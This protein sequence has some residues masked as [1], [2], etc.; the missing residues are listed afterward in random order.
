VRL[1]ASR[2]HRNRRAHRARVG[3]VPTDNIKRRPVI[4]TGAH[5]RKPDGDVDRLVERQQFH[6]DQPLVVIHR[7]DGVELPIARREKNRV[8]RIRAGDVDS[9][10]A[11]HHDRRRDD[12]LF[13]VAE[14]AVLAGVR[15]HARHRDARPGDVEPVHQGFVNQFDRLKHCANVKSSP[16]AVQPDMHRRQHYLSGPPAGIIA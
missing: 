16:Q 4:R 6:R 2:R 14:L 3:F 9:L 5:D 12:A 7:H 1:T 10:L 13:L 11:R 15:V 8:R